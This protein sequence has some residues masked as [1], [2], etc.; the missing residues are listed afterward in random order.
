MPDLISHLEEAKIWGPSY[1]SPTTSLI[2]QIYIG[3]SIEIF[4]KKH[5][6]TH[7]HSLMSSIFPQFPNFSMLI[8]DKSE[9]CTKL[10]LV[11]MVADLFL[12]YCYLIS[13]HFFWRNHEL[14]LIHSHSTSIILEAWQFFYILFSS[15]PVV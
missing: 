2:I 4:K 14:S 10:L 11:A 1:F 12:F 13:E 5:L 8:P 7:S 15:I 3:L 9:Y 6:K